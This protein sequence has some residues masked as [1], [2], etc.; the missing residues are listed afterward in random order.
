M[1][2]LENAETGVFRE[3]NIRKEQVKDGGSEHCY[4]M[5][6]PSHAKVAGHEEGLQGS[7]KTPLLLCEANCRSAKG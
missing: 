7:E 2:R 4:N 3:S 6:V 1:M 5:G